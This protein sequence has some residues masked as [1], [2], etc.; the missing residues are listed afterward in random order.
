M[1][2]TRSR[3]NLQHTSNS[4]A[5]AAN[6]A[7]VLDVSVGEDTGFCHSRYNDVVKHAAHAPTVILSSR[8]QRLLKRTSKILLEDVVDAFD[9]PLSAFPAESLVGAAILEPPKQKQCTPVLHETG[10]VMSCM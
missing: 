7:G 8:S 4:I 9:D 3:P 6:E 2:S 1:R 5:L 10:I